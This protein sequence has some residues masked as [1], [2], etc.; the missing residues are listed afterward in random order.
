GGEI[1]GVPIFNSVYRRHVLA[2]VVDLER[3]LGHGDALVRHLHV[4][5]QRAVVVPTARL[6]HLNVAQ[7][8]AWIHERLS[9]GRLLAA[10]RASVWGRARRLAYAGAFPLIALVLAR[11][12][13]PSAYRHGGAG[14][15]LGTVPA[16]LA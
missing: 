10:N 15:P 13:L 12:A 3:A 2:E 4:H 5:R 9:T 14:A 8:R 1:D 6:D 16:M 7:R 11:R